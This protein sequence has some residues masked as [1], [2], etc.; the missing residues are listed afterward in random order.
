MAISPYALWML[1]Q[2]AQALLTRLARVRSFALVEPM[3]PAATLLP[4]RAGRDRALPRCRRRR[5][6]QGR[7]WLSRWLRGPG[8]EAGNSSGG[9]APVHLSQAQVQCVITQFDLFNDVISQRSENETGVWLSG[10][11]VV[12][13]DALTLPGGY[14]DVPPVICY[15]DR[16]VGAA[17]RRARTRLPGGGANPV[18]IIRVPRERMI[19][20]GIA[21][22]LIHEVGH[23]GGGAA[24]SRELAAAGAAGVCSG[25]GA[26]S[27]RRGGCG[28]AGSPRSSRTSGRWRASASSSTMG[29]DGRGQPAAPVRVPPQR[30][31]S[32]SRAMDPRQA[33][34]R[35]GQGALPAS[36]MGAARRLWESFYPI[37]R[38]RRPS[39]SSCSR[40]C[41]QHAGLR[42]AARQPS[43]EGA[44]RALARRG[45]RRG[46]AP[47]GAIGRA[48]PRLEP[49]AGRRCI[50]PRPTLVFAVLGQAAADGQ[51]TPEDE[52]A[53]LAKAADALGAAQHARR[54][55]G[56]RVRI[57]TQ[58]RSRA[59][60]GCGVKSV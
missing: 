37:A 8:G 17:I 43:P 36:A 41:R 42:R 51:L 47:A 28:S 16:G 27:A 53:L 56:V 50:A 33:E 60:R 5:A 30:G 55:I 57:E 24:R 21:S 18:A 12:S 40:S 20:S 39:G 10:L 46:G 11:D 58:H 15:L 48:V 2:E 35:D 19:G 26:T 49:V 44:A 9:A 52:S 7:A 4:D 38:A 22:S 34:L 54:V 45:A 6:P 13:A 23:Q 1:S 32:A 14:Y 59:Q 31:R 29:L 25:G 3:L